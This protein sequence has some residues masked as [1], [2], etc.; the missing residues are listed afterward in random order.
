[1][2][3]VVIVDDAV[4]A[5]YLYTVTDEIQVFTHSIDDFE[6][7]IGSRGDDLF[8]ATGDADDFTGGDGSD[9]VD[10]GA[11]ELDGVTIDLSVGTASNGTADGDVYAE[12]EGL[13]GTAGADD[14]RGSDFDDHLM[15]RDGDDE[16]RGKKGNDLL[17]GGLGADVIRGGNGIDTATYWQSSAGVAIDLTADTAT[18]G[19]ATGDELDAI[20]NLT[21][22]DFGDTL[23]GDGEAN[24]LDGLDG[25]DSL[26]GLEGDDTLIG[27]SGADTLDGGGGSDWAIYDTDN[28]ITVSTAEVLAQA[29]GRGLDLLVDIENLQSGAGD[30]SLTGDT[31]A[32]ILDGGDGDNML[33]G[34]DGDDLLIQ[35]SFAS[36]TIEGGDGVD[37]LALGDGGLYDRPWQPGAARHRRGALAGQ[38][39]RGCW[40][41]ARA[42]T[43]SPQMR[44]R[45]PSSPAM[46]MTACKAARATTPSPRALVTIRCAG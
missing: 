13:F 29:T 42:M 31:G 24:R 10:F 44:S 38:R 11:A 4:V 28:D 22:S 1:M 3:A 2:A 18:G 25:N 9:T 26:S 32:N 45:R 35:G 37:T 21:G 36:A 33:V 16:L 43:R 6:S 23:T 39:D 8:Y 15:G 40:R 19:E 41:P 5:P 14:F 20:E 17:E 46:A 34:D 12:V 7:Y 27:G 30:D